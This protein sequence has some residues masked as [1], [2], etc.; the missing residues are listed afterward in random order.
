MN[1]RPAPHSCVPQAAAWTRIRCSDDGYEGWST[2]SHLTEIDEAGQVQGGHEQAANGLAGHAGSDHAQAG[3]VLTPEWVSEVEYDGHPMM[4]PLGSVLTR[5]RNGYAV[6]AKNRLYYKGEVWDPAAAKRDANT[7]RQLA[8]K[9]LN[10]PYLWGGKSVWGVDCSGFT[11]T[12]MKFFDVPLLRDAY[13]QAVQGEPVGFLE[14]ART[15]DLAF[16]DNEEGRI[17]HV[18]LLLNEHEII[19][20]SGQVR[21]DKIDNMGIVHAEN[22]QRTHQL[23]IIKR[24]MPG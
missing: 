3:H 19:H 15:G 5:M 6:R 12:V 20:A 23:R 14:E 18:G 13:Q 11:Q 21:I 7:I 8:S 4:I 16:F 1:P 24:V 9:F 22:F 10:T 17:T 2:A